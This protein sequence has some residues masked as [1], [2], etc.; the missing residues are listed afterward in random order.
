[1]SSVVDH[2]DGEAGAGDA[3]LLDGPAASLSFGR[4]SSAASHASMAALHQS[5]FDPQ[6]RCTPYPYQKTGSVVSALSVDPHTLQQAMPSLPLSTRQV[7]PRL[8]S[9]SWKE[10]YEDEVEGDEAHG[11]APPSPPEQCWSEG[12]AAAGSLPSDAKQPHNPVEVPASVHPAAE[13]SSIGPTKEELGA[14]DTNTGSI[15]ASSPTVRSPLP[16]LPA[17]PV[18]ITYEEGQVQRDAAMRLRRHSPSAP[19]RGA[20]SSATTQVASGAPPCF[21]Q[22]AASNNAYLRAVAMELVEGKPRGPQRRS[23]ETSEQAYKCAAAPLRYP[24]DDPNWPAAVRPVPVKLMRPASTV[25]PQ[26]SPPGCSPACSPSL[27]PAGASSVSFAKAATSTQPIRGIPLFVK[28][29]RPAEWASASPSSPTL[30]LRMSLEEYGRSQLQDEAVKWYHRCSALQQQLTEMQESYNRQSRLLAA[31]WRSA[32]GSD[33]GAKSGADAMCALPVETHE[34]ASNARSP[35]RRTSALTS[36]SPDTL[37]R[38]QACSEAEDGSYT[39]E[40]VEEREQLGS[41]D[42]QHSLSE[43]R[44]RM[45]VDDQAPREPTLGQLAEG[46]LQCRVP[47]TYTASS[48]SQGPTKD[49]LKRGFSSEVRRGPP[50][51][52]GPAAGSS[53]PMLRVS[54][55]LQTDDAASD[56]ES[57]AH[58]THD[59]SVPGLLSAFTKATGENPACFTSTPVPSAIMS[60]QYVAAMEEAAMLRKR[61]DGAERDLAELRAMYA[62]Q[63]LRCD[64]LETQLLGKEEKLLRFEQQEEL[65]PTALPS[66]DEALDLQLEA[67]PGTSLSVELDS[68]I[69][70]VRDLLTLMHRGSDDAPRELG[71]L[72]AGGQE[73]EAVLNTAQVDVTEAGYSTG[74]GDGTAPPLAKSSSEMHH[75]AA[76]THVVS[77]VALLVSLFTQLR[78][79]VTGSSQRFSALQAE[80]DVVR[81]DRNE[82]IGEQ[83]EQVRLLQR[84][85]LE[86]DQEQLKLLNDLHRAQEQLAV[87]TAQAQLAPSVANTHSGEPSALQHPLQREKQSERDTATVESGSTAQRSSFPGLE[88]VAGALPRPPPQRANALVNT[89]FI[90]D[91]TAAEVA[92]LQE[93]LAQVRSAAAAGQEAQRRVLSERLEQAELQLKETRLRAEDEYDRMSGTIEALTRE[94]AETKKA[95]QIKEVSLRIALRESFSPPLLLANQGDNALCHDVVTP[96]LVADSLVQASASSAAHSTVQLMR[97]MSHKS[98]VSSSSPKLGR[99]GECTS[100]SPSPPIP[101]HFQ[102]TPGARAGAMDV[103]DTES[104]GDRLRLAS[105]G[106]RE[107]HPRFEDHIT[108]HTLPSATMVHGEDSGEELGRASQV[109]P[110]S[111]G[112]L[113][114]AITATATSSSRQQSSQGMSMSICRGSRGGTSLPRGGS[115]A[116]PLMLGHAHSETETISREELPSSPARA[117][118]GHVPRATQEKAEGG[119]VA[120]TFEEQRFVS[121]SLPLPPPPPLRGPLFHSPASS[122]SPSPEQHVRTLPLHRQETNQGA[123]LGIHASV[124]KRGDQ[125][126][127][128][129]M[130]EYTALGSSATYT[131]KSLSPEAKLRHFLSSL[132]PSSS[133]FEG[134]VK[135]GAHSLPTSQ[136]PHTQRLTPHIM[137]DVKVAPDHLIPREEKGTTFSSTVSSGVPAGGHAETTPSRT[138]LTLDTSGTSPSQASTPAA[139]RLSS[140]LLFG[141]PFSTGAAARHVQASL[142]RHRETWEQQELILH[143]LQR[144]SSQ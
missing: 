44:K 126:V 20:I 10:F 129:P 67:A 119:A 15:R 123:R 76:P 23:R 27:S 125:Y 6:P 143:S 36:R 28:T 34:S 78:S 104:S 124:L 99:K 42:S 57:F 51:E 40:M 141:S 121:P 48:K 98:A 26:R 93:K 9:R 5:F 131:V 107:A 41:E 111:A 54:V 65:R 72:A 83:S 132:S 95:L 77:R 140:T 102:S 62:A 47:R 21:E 86:K 2:S 116:S 138:P 139:L 30:S 94:L 110:P 25:A 117:S 122:P 18:G 50:G 118:S 136:A 75:A 105:K 85:L 96:S 135:K 69:A 24:H 16:R 84:Q 115:D 14:V 92:A 60:K 128:A 7:L 17:A 61:V 11:L 58:G 55:G 134:S 114:A 82:L 144:S 91:T 70:Q 142:S 32:G 45:R 8:P 87:V 113:S 43:G 73:D 29:H 22:Y 38:A 100:M 97:S 49:S 90:A 13:S 101:P 79:A 74:L 103:M 39:E 112:A 46:R 127:A 33:A 35:S 106:K 89:A 1:M 71:P 37:F 109:A 133:P 4:S 66:R 88:A 12:V 31:Q 108:L 68:L 81:A 137:S 53:P 63:E 64:D 130:S 59:L 80:L 120:V 3:L 52:D 19:L 56:Q